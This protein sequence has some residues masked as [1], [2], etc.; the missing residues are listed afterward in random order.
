MPQP[1]KLAPLET[2][3]HSAAHILAQ[4]VKQLYPETKI[5]IGPPIDEG[6]YYDFDRQ[7]PFTLEDMEKIEK[8][9][10][11]IIAKD[12]PFIRSEV[13]KEDARKILQQLGEPYK[14]EILEWIEDEIVSFYSD[15]DFKDLCEGPHVASTGKV[16]AVKLLSVAGAYW[17][18]SEKNKM[19]QRI[20]GTAFPTEAEL[21]EFLRIRE[22]A[23]L[24][25]HRRLM[26]DLELM[27]IKEEAGAGLV[28]YHPKGAMIRYLIEEKM[29]QEHLKRGYQFVSTPHLLKSDVWIRSGHYQNYK[30]LMFIFKN[31]DGQEYGVKPMNCPGHILIYQSRTRSYREFP[32]RFFELGNVYRNEKSGVLHGTLRVRGFTQD[33]AHIFIMPEQL[34]QE[35]TAILDFTFDV[36]NQFGFKEYE[37]TLG[38]RPEKAIGTEEQWKQSE[39]T[40]Q[41]VGQRWLSEHKNM[42]MQIELGGGAFYGPKIDVKLKDAIGRFWQC[43]TIQVDFNLPERFDLNYIGQDGHHH[44][45]LMIHRAI[46]GSVERFIGTLIEHYAGSFPLWLAPVQV[47]ILPVTTEQV[48]YAR[49]VNEQFQEK[50]PDKLLRTYIGEGSETISK[51]IRDCEVQKIPYMLV[52]GAREAAAGTVAVRARGSK[53]DEGAIKLEDFLKK[54]QKELNS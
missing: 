31:D 23:K 20:Y 13:T 53:R 26:V 54:V 9:M 4:A 2:L 47:A 49:W 16:K 17:R 40:L 3:R 36:L 15:G 33:D 45:P 25:D 38:T 48:K 24:R 43:S 42:E 21:Q 7:T 11:E 8:Q 32:L 10:K 22:E 28:F 52:V 30:D 41:R 44:R 34:K 6:F 19:L 12:H 14:L 39:E 18:G 1:P 27:S 29:R 5:S 46:L 50:F 37:V 51:Q 35:I